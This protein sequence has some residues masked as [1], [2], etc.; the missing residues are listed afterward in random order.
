VYPGRQRYSLGGGVW[1]LPVGD[2]L[3]HVNRLTG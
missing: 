2:L 3:A 1:A